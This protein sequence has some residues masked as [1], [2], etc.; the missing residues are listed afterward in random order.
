[1]SLESKAELLYGIHSV[2]SITIFKLSGFEIVKREKFLIL[3]LEDGV[4][5][6]ALMRPIILYIVPKCKAL[7]MVKKCPSEMPQ[8]APNLLPHQACYDKIKIQIFLI[9]CL[10]P[11]NVEL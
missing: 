6:F 4:I 11:L 2:P 9:C 3:L 1:M 5:V 7:L 8:T 10:H